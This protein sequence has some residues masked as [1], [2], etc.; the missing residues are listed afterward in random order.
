[1]K[2][3]IL[4]SVSVV[5]LACMTNAHAGLIPSINPSLPKTYNQCLKTGASPSACQALLS[6][7]VN[8]QTKH[9]QDEEAWRDC[10]AAAEGAFHQSIAKGP[11]TEPYAGEILPVG[12][13]ESESDYWKKGPEHK[14]WNE[15]E[16]E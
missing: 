15:A 10:L 3:S 8:C 9:S 2:S 11:S 6:A 5:M 16:S 14:G 12:T 13:K 7:P 1:M 4:T